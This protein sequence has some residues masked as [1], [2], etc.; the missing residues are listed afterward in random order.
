MVF[1]HISNIPSRVKRF[2]RVKF[3]LT[4]PRSVQQQYL[5]NTH[6]CIAIQPAVGCYNS[7]ANTGIWCSGCSPLGKISLW[8]GTIRKR[9]A[10][11]RHESPKLWKMVKSCMYSFPPNIFD[12]VVRPRFSIEYPWLRKIWSKT[13]PWLRI[14]SPFLRDF[15]EF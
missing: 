2:R 6:T 14:M 10:F 3:V 15:K 8:N 7:W 12:G 11:F 13:Y 5:W 9:G 4:P 1:W